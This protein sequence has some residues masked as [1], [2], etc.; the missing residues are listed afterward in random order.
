MYTT[1]D[2][3]IYLIKDKKLVEC[4]IKNGKFIKTTKEINRPKSLERISNFD[5]I[6][7]NFSSKFNDVDE[8]PEV[9][10]NEVDEETTKVE[11][12]H[13]SKFTKEDTKD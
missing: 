4:E 2:G 10:P 1:L 3:K 6:R 8:D 11:P 13:N 7:R 5:E 9:E 12:K